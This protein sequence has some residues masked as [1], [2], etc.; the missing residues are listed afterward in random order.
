MLCS[1]AH[2]PTCRAHALPP[3]T[4]PPTNSPC[5]Q[6]TRKGDNATEAQALIDFAR[7]LAGGAPGVPRSKFL[8]DALQLPQVGVL[9]MA[10]VGV[11]GAEKDGLK[12]AVET[13]ALGCESNAIKYNQSKLAYSSPPDP[14]SVSHHQLPLQPPGHQPHGS[15]DHHPQPG[16][17]WGWGAV[18]WGGSCPLLLGRHCQQ[19][20]A[21]ATACLLPT[22]P[23]CSCAHVHRPP[24]LPQD[25]CTKNFFIYRDPASGQWSMFPWD[26]ESGEEGG[27]GGE[28]VVLVWRADAGSSPPFYVSPPFCWTTTPPCPPPTHR[29]PHTGFGTDRG[30]GGKPAPDYCIL[31][32]EQWNSPLYCDRNHP[33]VRVMG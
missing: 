15:P 8:F 3:C 12:A 14:P 17:G 9:F 1:L 10:A 5:A 4:A 25:R 7:G 30:L 27:G 11:A 29:C 26:P 2:P 19:P 33:Q 21:R 28:L 16:A 23:F 20:P 32:C 13:T 24:C 6:Y 18:Y 31:A 22:H